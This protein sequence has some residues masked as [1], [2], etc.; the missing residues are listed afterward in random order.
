[1]AMEMGCWPNRRELQMI[2]DIYGP[3][4]GKRDR[5]RR[6]QDMLLTTPRVRAFVRSWGESTPLWAG[7]PSAADL[8]QY[9]YPAWE[10]RIR[11]LLK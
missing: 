8:R 3:T 7:G 1:M 5:L 6:L 9:L 10:N 4:D 2:R 11:D